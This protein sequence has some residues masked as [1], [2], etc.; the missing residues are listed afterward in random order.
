[1]SV[2]CADPRPLVLAVDDEPSMLRFERAILE[3]EGFRVLT[4]GTGTEAIGV[5]MDA[6]PDVV[7]LDIVLPDMYGTLVCQR[8]RAFCP[9]AIIEVSGKRT[10]PDD[11]ALGLNQGAD[12]YVVKPF[13][14]SVLL[15]RV[16]AALRRRQRD[17]LS[18]AAE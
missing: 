18:L 16:R 7:L 17:G 11:R 5:A 1:M 15:A 4:A 12:D 10:S 13:A 2:E 8:I 3:A 9:A 14:S 6:H